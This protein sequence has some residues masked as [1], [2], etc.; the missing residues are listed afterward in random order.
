[1]KTKWEIFLMIAILVTIFIVAI[2]AGIMLLVFIMDEL[3]RIILS[4]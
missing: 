3:M 1:V 4:L 2:L